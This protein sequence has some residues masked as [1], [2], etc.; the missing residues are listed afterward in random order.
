ML[1]S[2]VSKRKRQFYHHYSVLSHLKIMNSMLKME[3]T[4][5]LMAGSVKHS[6]SLYIPLIM[7]T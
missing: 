2:P 4:A 3:K 7:L 5:K 6:Y 1:G